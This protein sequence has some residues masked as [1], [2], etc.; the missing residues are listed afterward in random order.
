MTAVTDY[1]LD[2]HHTLRQRFSALDRLR[3]AEPDELT[4][5]WRPL[6]DLLDL[7]AATEE[8]VFYPSLLHHGS[9]PDDETSDAIKDHNK[10]R[11]AVRAAD[12]ADVGSTPWWEAVDEAR[13]QNSDHMAEEERGAIADFRQHAEPALDAELGQRWESYR[14]EHPTATDLSRQAARDKDPDRYIA[15]NQ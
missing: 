6:G 7:H 1:I 13:A 4:A 3:E 5:A 15:E 9:S 12:S 11:D 14:R 10:I 8:S 2:D